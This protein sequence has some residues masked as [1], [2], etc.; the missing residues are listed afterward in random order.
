MK[1]YKEAFAEAEKCINITTEIYAEI[2]TMENDTFKYYFP[3]LDYYEMK[4]KISEEEEKEEKEITIKNI[5]FYRYWT[6]VKLCVK[7]GKVTAEILPDKKSPDRPPDERSNNGHGSCL[8][9][10]RY[11]ADAESAHKVCKIIKEHD[12][13]IQRRRISTTQGDVA[14]YVDGIFITYFGDEIE[15][16]DHVW[17]SAIP[18][19]SFLLALF[20]HPAESFYRFGKIVSDRLSLSEKE[21]EEWNLLF[22]SRSCRPLPGGNL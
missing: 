21:W 15:L 6:P 1:N 8:W 14:Y 10:T 12:F 20:W 4:C 19:G 11:F 9:K 5:Y 18:D 13:S 17:K 3:K 22:E 16:I 2:T 7:D